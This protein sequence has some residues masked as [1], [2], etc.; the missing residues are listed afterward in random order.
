[1]SDDDLAVGLLSSSCNDCY[2]DHVRMSN[3]SMLA[4]CNIC[5]AS[6]E[7]SK[8]VARFDF[9]EQ[10]WSLLIVWH[11][12][13]IIFFQTCKLQPKRE[14]SGYVMFCYVPADQTTL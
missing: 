10:S 9:M 6:L 5:M 14:E 11:A 12:K 8:E 1:M 3:N 4:R 13:E 7:I 2:R